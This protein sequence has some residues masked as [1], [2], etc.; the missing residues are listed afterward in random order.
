VTLTAEEFARCFQRGAPAL[1]TLAAGILGDRTEA[2]DVLQEA[3]LAAL[4]KLD[5]FDPGTNFQAWMGRFVRNVALN[6]SRKRARRQT[7]STDPALL[8][9]GPGAR[10]P[11][12]GK[13]V[14]PPRALFVRG[15]LALDQGDFDDRV[16]SGLRELARVPRACLLLRSVLELSYAEIAEL[17]AIPEGTAMSHVHRSR[18]FL[19]ARLSG[20]GG[21]PER[22]GLAT[23]AAE[24]Q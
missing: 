3:C 12:N 8:D 18:V 7:R 2:E 20:A 10:A 15:E 13:H 19:R 5:D 11:R 22:G 9:G 21:L 16:L 14:E 17:L 4:G 6:E 1:W 23:H 24:I